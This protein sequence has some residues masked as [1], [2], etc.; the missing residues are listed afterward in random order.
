MKFA[1]LKNLYLLYKAKYHGDTYK[2]I[3]RLLEEAK[4]LHKQDWLINPTIKGDH[5]QSWRAF[6]GKNLEKLIMF[7]IESE[8]NNLN[9]KIV[10]GSALEKQNLSP[11]LEQIKRYILVDYRCYG[12]HLPDVDLVIFDPEKISNVV[13]LSV[14]V[15]LRERIA[16][17]AYWKLKLLANSFTRGVQ[18]YFITLDE[19]ETLKT[20][21]PAKKGR[22]IV[23]CDLDACYVLTESEFEESAKVKKFDKLIPDLQAFFGRSQNS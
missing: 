20:H 10:N 5:E 22:A 18:V 1:D 6:K 13:L 23:E 16:Q 15:T 12:M 9:L 3:S 11:E 7:M 19:D 2:Y 21:Q 14:K 4:A 8:V 17:T